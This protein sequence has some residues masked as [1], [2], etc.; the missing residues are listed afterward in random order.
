MMKNL[1]ILM[2]LIIALSEI[3]AMDME[4][5]SLMYSNAVYDYMDENFE[6]DR[7]KYATISITPKKPHT[8]AKVGFY[9][10]ETK[11][12]IVYNFYFI[13]ECEVDECRATAFVDSIVD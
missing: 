5:E 9:D 11:Q 8:T 12:T 10:T 6:K 13:T 7:Y 2:I 4:A 1:L 3:F